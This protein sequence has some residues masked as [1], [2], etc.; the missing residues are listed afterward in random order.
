MVLEGDEVEADDVGEHCELKHRLGLRGQGG[1]EDPELELAAQVT[2]DDSRYYLSAQLSRPPE[3]RVHR[4]PPPVSSPSVLHRGDAAG[5]TSTPGQRIVR[6]THASIS[7]LTRSLH[8]QRF[9]RACESNVD[10]G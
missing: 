6:F 3:A 8:D 4:A 9:A 7:T 5:P 1:H 2:H 10:V